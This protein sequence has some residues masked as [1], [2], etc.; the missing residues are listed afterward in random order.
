M[1]V[2]SIATGASLNTR[3]DVPQP[4][5]ADYNTAAE[6]TIT[7]QRLPYPHSQCIR[8]VRQFVRQFGAVHRWAPQDRG[9]VAS[10]FCANVAMWQVARSS[11]SY[12][13]VWRLRAGVNC[14][15][16]ER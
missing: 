10:G 11:E 2:T 3:P 8:S 12:E 14:E 13:R 9:S 4:E 6:R 15:T 5:N 7:P 1:W 16:V